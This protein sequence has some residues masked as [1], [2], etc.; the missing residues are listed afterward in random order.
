MAN[1]NPL[2]VAIGS[3]RE[4]AFV[5]RR[6]LFQREHAGHFMPVGY[7]GAANT[8]TSALNVVQNIPQ[9]NVRS[10]Q[11]TNDPILVN[12]DRQL[13]LKVLGSQSVT[14]V[15]VDRFEHLLDG[16]S[17]AL[18]RYLVDG[19]RFGFRIH[20]IGEL[21]QFES[22][23]LKSA[24]QSPEVA[25][26]K[27]MK[28]IDAGRIAGPFNNAPFPVFRTSPIGI[29]PKKTPND[30][31]LIHH[32]SYPKGS[33]INDSIPDDCSSVHY[34]TI[35]DA[36]HILKNLGVGCYMAKTDIKSAFRII[37]VHPLDYPLLGIK[38]A[39]HYYFDRCLAM[40]LKSSCAIFE[41]FS[42]SLEWLALH[43]LKVSAVL[44][45]LDDFLF[46][47]PSQAQCRTDLT[48]FLGMCDFLGVP[49]AQEKTVG[50]DSIL[51][52]AGIELDS[53]QQEARLPL[54]KLT[55]CRTLLHRFYKKR[56]V[57]LRE[58]QSLI[59]LLNFCCSVVVPG[60]AFLRRLIHLTTGLIR[61]H[62]HIRLNKEAKQ[63]IRM[64][65]KF[66]D[67]FNGRAFFSVRS[68][69]NILYTRVVYRCRGIERL[70]CHIWKAMV[71]W[72]FPSNMAL[73]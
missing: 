2:L 62:H 25:F 26:A 31:R 13:T 57:T 43:H 32:L 21:S 41:K 7:A 73:H 44:H 24:L 39:D 1:L 64:W 71:W 30:F 63:D 18:K 5:P 54:E 52:F 49:I 23:N 9:V 8:S 35:S 10:P 61:P 59:G 33:S 47:A 42:S 17:P 38:W 3:P 48:N 28:E 15:K 58:L 14:P 11:S 60:R 65:L 6:V 40:G 19:F 72:R 50:P 66:L 56:S 34:A 70:R 22:P 4:H 16:Y 55:K 45:I 67:N 29:V 27:L 12:P 46:I 68:M 20:F 37:P 53:V 51:Q 36:V 69:G